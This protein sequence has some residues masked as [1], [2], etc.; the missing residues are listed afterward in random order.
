MKQLTNDIYRTKKKLELLES[1]GIGQLLVDFMAEYNS[2]KHESW[3]YEQDTQL[4]ISE[5]K[6]QYL[7]IMQDYKPSKQLKI[8]YNEENI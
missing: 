2:N 4:I 5:I 3:V 7:K 8:E 6:Q 1:E